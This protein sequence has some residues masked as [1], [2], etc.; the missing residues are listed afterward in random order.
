M[1]IA[2]VHPHAIDQFRQR[3]GCKKSDDY[4]R[5]KLIDIAKKS[6]VATFVH[7]KYAVKA[8]LN[9]KCEIATYLM[10]SCWLI[11]V[12]KDQIR[13]IHR[14]EAKRWIVVK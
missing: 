9:H 12:V 3:T 13:T 10:D 6:K 4:I 8:L 2:D 11:V 5:G 1:D 14:N 7:P